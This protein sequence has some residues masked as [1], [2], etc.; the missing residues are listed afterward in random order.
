MGYI[1]DKYA[2]NTNSYTFKCDNPVYTKLKDLYTK[3]GEKHVYK[4]R[5]LYIADKGEYPHPVAA[6]DV[7][8]FVDLPPHLMETVKAMRADSVTTDLINKGVVGFT[9]Y[10]YES[11]KRKTAC[12]SVD[13]VDLDEAPDMSDDDMPFPVE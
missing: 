4:L 13:W 7:N 9:I 12:Y 5:A 6:A 11:K 10:T 2:K 8:T 3:N 1:K